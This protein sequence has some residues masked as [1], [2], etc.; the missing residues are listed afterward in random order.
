MRDFMHVVSMFRF[1]I[2]YRHIS[3]M[4]LYKVIKLSIEDVPYARFLD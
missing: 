2:V 3:M 1:L 4:N